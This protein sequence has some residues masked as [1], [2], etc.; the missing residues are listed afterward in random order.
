MFV[1]KTNNRCFA[2]L[3]FKNMKLVS[4]VARFADYNTI[5]NIIGQRLYIPKINVS[6]KSEVEYIDFDII[7]A[8]TVKDFKLVEV[9][10]LD[11]ESDTM[12]VLYCKNFE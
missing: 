1:I 6:I 4:K 7:N 8:F 10:S 3:G 2:G 11:Y 9:M 12:I 5:Y